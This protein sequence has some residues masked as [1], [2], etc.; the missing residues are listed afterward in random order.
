MQGFLTR[1]RRT[2][3]TVFVDHFSALS[4]VHFQKSTLAAET[5]ETAEGKRDFERQA[6]RHGVTVNHHHADD[7]VF[8]EAESR[9]C[10]LMV[11]RLAAVQSMRIIRMEKG[12]R[13]FVSCRS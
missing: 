4:H 12:K 5:A 11:K 1:Q 13:R 7:G 3:T 8:A 9:H 10:R 2:V 6:K